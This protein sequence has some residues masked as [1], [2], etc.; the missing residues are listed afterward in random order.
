MH[1]KFILP[2]NFTKLT[3]LTENVIFAYLF[4]SEFIHFNHYEGFNQDPVGRT[5]FK[6]K[7]IDYETKYV[8]INI[9][10]KKAFLS[11][12]TN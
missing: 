5:E 4:E 9:K 11:K 8:N 1:V 3:Y 10:F 12:I 6:L 7:I 2:G